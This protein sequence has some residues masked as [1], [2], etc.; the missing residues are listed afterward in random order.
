MYAQKTTDD[1]L[2][3]F[4]IENGQLILKDGRVAAGFRI[5]PVEMESR[6]AGQYQALADYWVGATKTLL[7]GATVQRLDCYYYQPFRASHADKAYFE[8]SFINHFHNR[9]V[10]QHRS[11]LFLSLGNPGQPE[12]NPVNTLFAWGKP[13][14]MNN[15]FGGIESRMEDLPRLAREFTGMLSASG[16]GVKP[17]DEKELAEVYRMYF[18]LEFD[19]VSEALQRPFHA[20]GNHA[21]LGEKKLNVV[22]MLHQ[23]Y[24]VK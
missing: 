1:L 12:P 8:R 10:L 19:A 15:P 17:M 4:A 20:E 2:P 3:I 16:V 23:V 5:Q 24:V 18:N 11:Y 21:V 13:F 9:L 22:S 14:L 6:P 7:V